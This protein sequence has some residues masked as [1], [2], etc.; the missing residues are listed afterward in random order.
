MYSSL[1][2]YGQHRRSQRPELTDNN[3][4]QV[5]FVQIAERRNTKR[6]QQWLS[7][8]DSVRA[9]A[10]TNLVL[11]VPKQRKAIKIDRRMSV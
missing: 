9:G 1:E 10:P 11:F 5:G 4:V 7:E 3:T 6:Q 8:V 2:E